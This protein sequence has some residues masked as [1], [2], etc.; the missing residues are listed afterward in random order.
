MLN[1]QPIPSNQQ[2]GQSIPIRWI[3]SDLDGT[4]LDSR[5]Q[6]PPELV[7]RIA[8]FTQS[9]GRFTFATGRTLSAAMPFISLLQV[10]S[11]VIL[12]NGARIYDPVSGTYLTE[13]YL[14]PAAVRHVMRMYEEAG[15]AGHLDLLLFHQEGIFSTAISEQVKQQMR[16][17]GVVI[18]KASPLW[19]E[20][21][22]GKVTKLMLLG[23]E[24]EIISFQIAASAIPLNTVQSE[25]QLLEV[26]P[27]GIN[28]SI[29]L[30]AMI[31]LVGAEADGF[32]AV[33]D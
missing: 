7:R 22:S 24:A 10:T 1:K 32:A 2:T 6:I 33:G 26:L 15:T 12:F 27:S 17:D 9:G 20:S 23:P 28:K 5:Q 18:E 29:A 16:K 21:I 4:L 31:R 25:R 19:M 3:V 30:S 13:H 14:E 11:P 8:R